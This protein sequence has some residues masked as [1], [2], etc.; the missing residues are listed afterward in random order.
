MFKAMALIATLAATL[1][2]CGPTRF[3]ELSY[4]VDVDGDQ[5]VALFTCRKSSSGQCVFR[6]DGNAS[7]AT[8]TVAVNET[9]AVS[10]VGAGT[11]YCSTSGG[12]GAMCQAQT[13]QLGKQTIRHSKRSS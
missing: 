10:G 3:D 4:S 12:D 7:P 5:R 13:L 6:F 11:S 8:A 1:A 2:A 9:G